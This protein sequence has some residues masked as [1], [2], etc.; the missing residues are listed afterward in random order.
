MVP[1]SGGAGSLTVSTTRDCT[2]AAS[3]TAQWIVITSATSGQG[4]GSIAYRVA[5]NSAPAAR[6]ANID[7]NTVSATVVQDAAE[8]RF[9]VTPAAPAVGAAAGRVTIQ[10][11]ANAA[12]PWTAATDAGW[13]RIVGGASGQGDGA[14]TLGVDANAG[15]ARSALINV[16][17]TQ[18]TLEQA[19]GLYPPPSPGCS[20]TFS[21]AG[22]P[23]RPQAGPALST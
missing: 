22:R 2:W 5:A 16:A 17:G 4:E 7:V 11:Q 9:T 6:R 1:A 18:V 12:C 10:V 8:C 20:Y 13:V 23:F 14:V 15:A 21:P 3:N 19:S